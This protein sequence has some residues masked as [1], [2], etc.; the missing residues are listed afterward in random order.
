[1][2]V[3]T[4]VVGSSLLQLAH[5]IFSSQMPK[6]SN[7]LCGALEVTELEVLNLFYTPLVSQ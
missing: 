4:T 1:M 2:Y 6:G 7:L 3:I 5:N